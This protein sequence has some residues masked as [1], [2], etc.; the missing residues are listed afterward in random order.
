MI[1]QV[2]SRSADQLVVRIW[3]HLALRMSPQYQYLGGLWQQWQIFQKSF[4]FSGQ[5][6]GNTYSIIPNTGSMHFSQYLA[7]IQKISPEDRSYSSPCR[8]YALCNPKPDY[9][10]PVDDS[11]DGAWEHDDC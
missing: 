8:S 4:S 3:L 11:V 10:K 2:I 5:F 7:G 9:T 1:H 6:E